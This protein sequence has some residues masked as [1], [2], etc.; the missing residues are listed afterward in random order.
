MAKYFK[1]SEFACRCGCGLSA[2]DPNLIKL[3]DAA[4][5]IFGRPIIITSGT[6]CEKHNAAIGG[7]KNSAHLV[8]PD[9]YSKAVDIKCLDCRT[10]FLLVSIFL[11]LGIKRFEITNKHIHVDIADDLPQEIIDLAWI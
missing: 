3:L 4:R 6:R 8:R 2:V 10:R 7:A 11:S 9:G 5:A 1:P